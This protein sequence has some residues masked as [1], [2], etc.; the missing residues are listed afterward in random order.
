MSKKQTKAAVMNA[1]F[2]R[3]GATPAAEKAIVKRLKMSPRTAHIYAWRYARVGSVSKAPLKKKGG[4][5][6]RGGK[7]I[8]P[9]PRKKKTKR[10]VR[11]SS[12]VA[13]TS[14]VI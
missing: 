9:K 6:W 1:I 11:A 4:E 13:V 8:R 5:G 10:Q 7:V 14:A 12:P 2:K 3:M